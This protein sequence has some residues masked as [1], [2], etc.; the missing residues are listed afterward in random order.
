MWRLW[1]HSLKGAQLLLLSAACLHT[2]QSRSYLNHLVFVKAMNKKAKNS[3]CKTKLSTNNE[4]WDNRRYFH[5][6]S[7]KTA[8]FKTPTSKINWMLPREQFGTHFETHEAT[9]GV[10]K[11]QKI[12][13][14]LCG[15]RCR[16]SVPLGWTMSLKLHF[17]WAQL[18]F[19]PRNMGARLWRSRWG[20]PSGYIVNG[21][22][23]SGE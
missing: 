10:I 13:H 20:V 19:F 3:I 23:Y 17:L 2:N 18:D 4:G 7:S 6:S 21:K 14:N 5:R 11:N 16:Y 12:T 22:T 9:P 8:Y 1:L 15:S